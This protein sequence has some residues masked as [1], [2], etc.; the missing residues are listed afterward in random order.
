MQV[1]ILEEA[2]RRQVEEVA[3]LAAAEQREAEWQAQVS[4]LSR[5]QT[6]SFL[7]LHVLHYMRQCLHAFVLALACS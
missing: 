6:P 3:A 1:R 2:H 4:A 7:L 5:A